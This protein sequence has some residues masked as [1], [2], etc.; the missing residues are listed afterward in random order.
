MNDYYKKKYLKYKNKY[1]ELKQQKGGGKPLI[2][3]FSLINLFNDSEMEEYLNPIYGLILSESGIVSNNYWLHKFQLIDTDFTKKII[4][5]T[6]NINDDTLVI[7]TN[8]ILKNMGPIDI[9]RY[10]ALLYIFKNNSGVIKLTTKGK[11][12]NSDISEETKRLLE[13]YLTKVK[14]I[15][16]NIPLGTKNIE[17]F[18]LI[19]YFLWWVANNDEGIQEYYNGLN[20]IFAIFNLYGL[21]IKRP[22]KIEEPVL[23]IINFFFSAP[24]SQ[25]KTKQN[26]EEIVYKITNKPF[27]VYDQEWSRNFKDLE[28]LY[29]DCGETTVRNFINLLYFNMS[30]NQFNVNEKATKELKEYYTTFNNFE[31]QSNNKKEIIYGQEL[32][33]RDAWSYLVINYAKNN[34]KFKHDGYDLLPGMSTDNK[35]TN[36]FQLI[37]NLLPSINNWQ[38]FISQDILSIVDRTQNGLGDIIINHK[39]FNIIIIHCLKGHYYFEIIKENDI[40]IDIDSFNP[41]Q[42]DIIKILTGETKISVDN[43]IFYNINKDEFVKLYNYSNDLKL[44]LKLLELSMTNKYDKET[45]KRLQIDIEDE[46]ILQIFKNQNDKGNININDYTFNSNDFEFVKLLNNLICI[47]FEIKNKDIETIDL[48]P[49]K[50]I[51]IIGD[52]FLDRC[53]KLITI[54]LDPLINVS[55]IGEYFLS[56]CRSLT[57]IT[58]NNGFKNVHTINRGFLSNSSAFTNINLASLINLE[59]IGNDFLSGCGNL[60]TVDCTSLIKVKTIGTNFISVC[61]NLTDVNLSGFYNVVSIDNLFM[62]LCYKL[63]SL[64]LTSLA[65][66]KKI[67]HS[68]LSV[69]KNLKTLDLTPLN[70]VELIG[71]DFLYRSNNV[72]VKCTTEFFTKLKKF[73]RK[74]EIPL[75]NITII[76]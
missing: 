60:K 17:D 62:H 43:Y 76:N 49:L 67:G 36:L 72:K 16:Q 4:N 23:K 59:K 31:K 29:P 5:L 58:L 1:L 74:I 38:N 55:V 35:E 51:E 32:N 18:H 8:K 11:I 24:N 45:R 41:K 10:I 40:D 44:K 28:S 47:N 19:L 22:I 34:L 6:H 3:D 53:Q 57:T 46:K 37:K 54:N 52:Y 33:A 61:R 27:K 70:N 2:T 20:E 75:E 56:E 13:S 50:N 39:Y 14:L 12:I 64:D 65:N 69:C 25:K 30:T 48:S 21:P 66:V 7:P 68:F 73:Q 42:R 26:F 15:K 9:G 71:Y 63:E